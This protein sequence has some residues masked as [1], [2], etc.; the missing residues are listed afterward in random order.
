LN[1][2][3]VFT[4]AGEV[5][6]IELGKVF[7]IIKPQKATPCPGTPGYINGIFELR[8]IVIPLMDLRRRLGVDPSPEKEKIIIVYIHGEQIGLLVDTIVEIISIDLTDIS[9]PP[10]IFKGIKPEYLSGIARLSE[11]LIIILNL[12]NLMTSE[13]IMQLGDITESSSVEELDSKENDQKDT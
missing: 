2:F 11:K 9:P 3:I 10:S 5:F 1:K 13:E 6:G 7:E 8:G 12:D 4:I